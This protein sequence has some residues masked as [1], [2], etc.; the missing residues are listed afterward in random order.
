MA[1]ALGL[2]AAAVPIAAAVALG[3]EVQV[4]SVRAEERGPSDVELQ[5]V[6]AR[7]RRLVGYRSFR[8][9]QQERRQCTWR[10]P[11]EFVI[12]GR[13]SLRIM[14]KGLHNEAG[15]MQG[16]LFDGR[17]RL[18]GTDGRLPDRGAPPLGVGPP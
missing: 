3:M 15:M 1:A 5:P 8:V 6:R 4:V 17:P 13:R 16:R 18:G 12:P 10:N 9:V 7:L 14:P 2:L 11:E